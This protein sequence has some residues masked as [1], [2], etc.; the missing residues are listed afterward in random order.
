MAVAPL[1]FVFLGLRGDEQ[2][3]EVTKTLRSLGDRGA[4]RVLDIAYMTKQEDGTFTPAQE[5]TTMTDQE[6]QQLGAAVGALV[7]IGYGGLYG[8][9]QGA[10][11]GAMI[12]AQMGA[13]A[14]DGVV[15]SF[16]Q[17][18][19]GESVQDVRDHI[20]DLAA[21]VPPGATGAIALIEHRWMLDLKDQ[22]QRAG[23]TVLGSGMI[24]PRS[25]VMLGATIAAAQQTAVQ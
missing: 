4:I 11:Q 6:R 20:R 18:D 10:K 13:Q 22:L 24:R 8:G 2:R 9:K 21:D 3:S 15:A 17:E 7:G 19:F 16:A 14:G 1:Q 25:L 5:Y 23:I 12:G